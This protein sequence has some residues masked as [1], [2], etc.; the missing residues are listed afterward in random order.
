M[1][2]AFNTK[3][4]INY[5]QRFTHTRPTLN[6]QL[7]KNKHCFVGVADGPQE[8]LTLRMR[9]TFP[10]KKTLFLTFICQL[11]RA[12]TRQSFAG[13]GYVKAIPRTSS[14]CILYLCTIKQLLFPNFHN[15]NFFHTTEG[16]ELL[17]YT[18]QALKKTFY[19]T[20]APCS[21]LFKTCSKHHHRVVR[22]AEVLQRW[23]GG[24]LDH[25]RRAAL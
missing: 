15:F 2:R 5:K 25:R 1:G 4:C 18:N 9:H 20:R 19:I 22:E 10:D 8:V 11:R 7:L 16:G 3:I 13:V 24:F 21:A 14:F 6:D 23:N 12:S 17:Y